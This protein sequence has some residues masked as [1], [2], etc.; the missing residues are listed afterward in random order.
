L[1]CS[2]WGADHLPPLQAKI[3]SGPPSGRCLHDTN[4]LISLLDVSPGLYKGQRSKGTLACL[5]ILT[6]STTTTDFGLLQRLRPQ[7]RCLPSSIDLPGCTTKHRSEVFVTDT[8]RPAGR[9]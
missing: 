5:Y 3:W 8:L 6:F 7:A 1:S 2:K 9:E 4:L